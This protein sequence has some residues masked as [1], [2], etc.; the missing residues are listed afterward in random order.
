MKKLW[1]FLLLVLLSVVSFAQPLRDSVK[2]NTPYFNIIYSEVLEQPL[3]AFYRVVCP[4]S[5]TPR[6]GFNFYT[7]PL[8]HTSD[9]ADYVNNVWDKGH[10]APVGS[11]RCHRNM[12]YATFTYANCV[13]QHQQLNRGVWR[14]L[15]S[16]EQKLATEYEEVYVNIR[17]VFNPKSNPLPTGATIPLGF[18]KTI[19]YG[20][21][22]GFTEEIYYFPNTEP[23]SKELNYYKIQ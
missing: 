11:I 19:K 4:E 6:S 8:L 1:L 17:V 3:S 10:L 2:F 18:Y 12:V 20:D 5:N 9:D 14:T 21:R 7:E 16:Y 15:E 23:I 22:F 13:L